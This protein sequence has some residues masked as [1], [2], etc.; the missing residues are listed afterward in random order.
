MRNM[1]EEKPPPGDTQQPDAQ[2]DLVYR[3]YTHPLV[4]SLY[5]ESRWFGRTTL[6]PSK[7]E[8]DAQA[9]ADQQL[10][11][12]RAAVTNAGAD[13]VAARADLA[14][15]QTVVRSLDTPADL[16]KVRLPSYIAPRSFALALLDTVA[17]AVAGTN[18]DGTPRAD[19]DVIRETREA[20]ESLSIPDSVKHRLLSLLDAARGDIDAFRRNVEAW[21]DDTM[22]RVSGWYKRRAQ[23]IIL[24]LAVLLTVALNANTLTIVERLWR[25][26]TLRATLVS[27]A[28]SAQLPDTDTAAKAKLK[29]AADAVDSVSK[30][31]VPLG[32][33]QSNKND[34]RH[35]DLA[36]WRGR[37]R[38]VGGW[39][40]TILAVSLGAPFWFDTLSR[41]S[42]LRGTGKPETPLPASGR[43]QLNERVV[44]GTPPVNV[45]VQQVPAIAA[46]SAPDAQT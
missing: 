8:E 21:F 14:K 30:A 43:G 24:V 11:A 38:W 18:P 13:P 34:P 12:A 40:L 9:E 35:I 25:D 23:L 46:A 10:S 39:L 19:H 27:Q 16:G 36:T 6:S 37:A 42:R 45:A 17:P 26:P 2:R 7:G 4:R 22:A 28:G 44:T 32:W 3:V 15:A 1:L 31:G 29:A 5:R 33:A 20:I 41:L